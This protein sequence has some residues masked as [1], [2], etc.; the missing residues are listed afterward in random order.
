MVNFSYFNF[1]V[2]LFFFTQAVKT[3][4]HFI[5]EHEHLDSVEVTV[6]CPFVIAKNKT[7]AS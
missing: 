2:C 7:V 3:I 4:L 6:F 1:F 5:P